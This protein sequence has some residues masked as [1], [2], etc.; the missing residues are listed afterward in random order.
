M[1]K[2][3]IKRL[4]TSVFKKHLNVLGFILLRL[5]KWFMMHELNMFQK[6]STDVWVCG[7]DCWYNN[8]QTCSSNESALHQFPAALL[9]LIGLVCRRVWA[10]RLVCSSRCVWK[11]QDWAWTS[12]ERSD[13]I[14]NT[15][16]LLKKSWHH[17][18][19]LTTATWCLHS[20]RHY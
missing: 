15:F 7:A 9:F 17:I 18:L 16:T 4:S 12:R 11:M 8:L 14:L 1:N 10:L 5:S 2:N 20:S 6:N 13:H 19:R 3:F